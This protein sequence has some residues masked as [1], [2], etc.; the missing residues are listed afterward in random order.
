MASKPYSASLVRDPGR[1]FYS[2]KFR[3]PRRFTAD[4]KPGLNVRRGLGTDVEAEARHLVDQM[5]QLL[6][7][8]SLWAPTAREAAARRF[9][10]KIV[11]AFYTGL[12]ATPAD[13]A[14]K[15]DR[16]LPLPGRDEG[17]RRVLL[18]GTFG[19]GKTTLVRQ[20]LGTDPE[21]ERFPATSS[22]RT[23]TSKL[24]VVLADGPFRAVATFLH[25]D[26]VRQYV[27]E[28][29]VEAALSQLTD[30]RED[31]VA[32]RLLEHRESRF[33]LGYVLGTLPTRSSKFVKAFDGGD[34]QADKGPRKDN[35]ARDKELDLL[36]EVEREAMRET[37][38][39][40]LGRIRAMTVDWQDR[41]AATQPAGDL[42]EFKQR[43]EE[44]LPE[45]PDFATLVDDI[46]AEINRRFADQP[47]GQM[48]ID[49]D[50][51]P[52]LW[53]IT[54]DDRAEF[55]RAI[56]RLT[57]NHE[58]HFGRLLTPLVEGV[59][60]VGPFRPRWRDAG[61]PPR[62]VLIDG[63]GLGHRVEA[64]A[65]VP[66]SIS[67]LFSEVDVILL[68]DTASAPMQATPTNAVKTIV[69]AG[70]ESKLMICFTHFDQ[71][72]G[73]NLPDDQA[74]MNHVLHAVTGMLN[75][76]S[77]DVDQAAEAALERYLQ[78]R[79]FFA[80]HLNRAKFPAEDQLTRT[81]L[82][83]LLDAIETIAE[84]DRTD[85]QLYYEEYK[86][87]LGIRAGLVNYHQI[88]RGLLGLEARPEAAK[89]HWAR[90]KALA[91]HIGFLGKDHYAQL[92][93]AANLVD[94]LIAELGHYLAQPH[95][96]AP[97]DVEDDVRLAAIARVKNKVHT[98]LLDLSRKLLIADRS[99]DWQAAYGFSGSGSSAKRAQA[100][101]EILEAAAPLADGLYSTGGE[102]LF[103]VIRDLVRDAI[104]E[105]GGGRLVNDPTV[106]AGSPERA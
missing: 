97:K 99:T 89:E 103:A 62:L 33:R 36:T 50:G 100:I 31:E 86:L 40:Y 55:M 20:I 94:L 65:S 84:P 24:E 73:D 77:Q 79:V 35:A 34:G 1:N 60:V 90:I 58:R 6:A 106:T 75:R 37:L 45:Q 54:T 51:W 39:G 104:R 28:C 10:P 57:G 11:E 3:H 14:L 70:Y 4:G 68:V 87:P 71:V 69:S 95:R 67:R 72:E 32:R 46:C 96:T 16:L 25:R 91:R 101:R 74:K 13:P 12:G 105:V 8:E 19:A 9:H 80:A 82:G 52:T 56:R 27:E 61:E 78:D 41:S 59:R 92:Q 29:V 47:G 30:G 102:D 42:D 26:E 64:I 88:W 83:D 2:I 22:N 44:Q 81:H 49:R 98:G 15:R 63:E 17:Y 43:Y 21:T 23:T 48:E 5:D 66:T 53:H 7:D 38:R 76:I 93:P 85:V 18:V